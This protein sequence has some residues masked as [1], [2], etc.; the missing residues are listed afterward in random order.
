M[1]REVKPDWELVNDVGLH[2]LNDRNLLKRALAFFEMNVHFYPDESRS[3]VAL[4][5][6]YASQ[7]EKPVAI[8]Y[9]KKAI[10]I[11]GNEDAKGKLEQLQK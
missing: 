7:K 10:E 4:G 9:Y 3:Y 1:K 11:D 5:T 8:K 6:Y 2:L